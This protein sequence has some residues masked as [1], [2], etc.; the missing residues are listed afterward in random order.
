LKRTEFEETVKDLKPYDHVVIVVRGNYE[1][2]TSEGLLFKV[3]DGRVLLNHG[4]GHSYQRIVS[5]SKKEAQS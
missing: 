1:N 3:R 5:I 4:P 2:Y